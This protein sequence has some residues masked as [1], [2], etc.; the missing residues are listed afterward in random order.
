MIERES[1]RRKGKRREGLMEGGW[2]KGEE[3][4]REKV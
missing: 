4:G 2:K 3:N 1:M